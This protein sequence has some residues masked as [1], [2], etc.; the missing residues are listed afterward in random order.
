MTVIREA[1]ARVAVCTVDGMVLSAAV[2]VANLE[3]S[4]GLGCIANNQPRKNRGIVPYR[5]HGSIHSR[6]RRCRGIEL[7]L[8]HVALLALVDF[9]PGERIAPAPMIPAGNA[10]AEHRHVG[11]AND[12]RDELRQHCIGG[13]TIGDSF[14]CKELDENGIGVHR[15]LTLLARWRQ[16][17]EKCSSGEGHKTTRWTK[18]MASL[19]NYRYLELVPRIAR[20]RDRVQAGFEQYS[21][22]VRREYRR[23]CLVIR[24]ERGI[25]PLG[26]SWM[27]LS[28]ERKTRR[29]VRNRREEMTR[30]L[31]AEGSADGTP[32][33]F[34]HTE[35]CLASC[36]GGLSS[37][38]VAC[39]PVPAE[40]HEC[41]SQQTRAKQHQ[42]G[43]LWSY[44][45]VFL[46]CDVI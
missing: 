33:C 11:I 1:F 18:R 34:N 17:R 45:E 15:A 44:G 36:R 12:L 26:G 24:T 8:T 2:R 13:L 29:S 4:F 30:G 7:K 27:K 46:A 42:R 19:G 14:R 43:G 23:L 20:K 38:S 41:C 37:G 35:A 6:L 32:F 40:E 9:V 39:V 25:H 3:R 21:R 5:L 16:T 10:L 28:T 31:K 22:V